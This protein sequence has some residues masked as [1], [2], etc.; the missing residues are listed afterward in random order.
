M[1]VFAP[2]RSTARYA[3]CLTVR[4]SINS[5]QATSAYVFPADSSVRTSTIRG[6]RCLSGLSIGY[7]RNE[8]SIDQPGDV[9]TG[10]LLLQA[11]P[12]GRRSTNSTRAIWAGR[13]ARLTVFR[14]A[15]WAAAPDRTLIIS[16]VFQ[17]HS[18]CVS[19]MAAYLVC[20]PTMPGLPRQSAPGRIR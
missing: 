15:N 18:H 8:R 9:R 17:I 13:F 2:R 7:R 20:V 6:D 4:T 12:T 3:C 16:K 19:L 11:R 5:M 1:T 10:L 14:V